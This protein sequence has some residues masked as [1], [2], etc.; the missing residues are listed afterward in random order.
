ML[1]RLWRGCSNGTRSDFDVILVVY[2]LVVVG[3][4]KAAVIDN[5]DR[6]TILRF[7]GLN[8]AG[9]SWSRQIGTVDFA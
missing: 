1:P 9:G 3:V 8:D 5:D 7:I 6:K 2:V 4:V